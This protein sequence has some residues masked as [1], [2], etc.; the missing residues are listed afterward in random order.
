MQLGVSSSDVLLSIIDQAKSGPDLPAAA[1]LDRSLTYDELVHEVA[2]VAAGL[3]DAGVVEGDRVALLLANS[4]N[5]VVA[6]LASLWLGATFVPFAVT[7]PDIRLISIATDC[8]PTVVVTSR[9]SDGALAHTPLLDLFAYRVFDELARGAE[10]PIATLDAS[11]IAYVIYTSGTTGAPKGVL[12]NRG[13][14]ASAVTVTA[15]ALGLSRTTRTL[16]VS[17]FHFDGSFGTLF[18]TLFAGGAVVIRPRDALLF[19]RT[20]FRAIKDERITY[21]GFSPSY[22][23]LL[24]ASPQIAELSE[25]DIDVIALGGEA[26]SV[27]D[28]RSLHAYAPNIRVFN[29]YGPTE[30]TIAVTHVHLTPEL[31]E[32]GVVPIGVPH[33]DV[34]FY[35]IDDAGQLIEDPDLMGELYIGGSQLMTGYWGAPELTAAVLRSDVVPGT[36]VYRT[37]DLMSRDRTGN[38]LYAGRSDDVIKRSGVRLSLMELSE[39]VRAIEHVTAAACLTFELEGAL[40]IAA[41]IVTDKP[42]TEFE[43]QLAARERLPDSMLPDRFFVVDE[44]PLTKSGKLDER[45]LLAEAALVTLRPTM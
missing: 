42:M 28:V 33:R 40:G 20:F 14:F 7:D 34:Y 31:V 5:F 23:R 37:G 6:A 27:S 17:P 16:C 21:T 9:E 4:V 11:S 38:Y 8:A 1:D 12:I 2:R 25:S 32:A 19:P 3:R 36:T 44:L 29:R 30:S 35:L 13:A 24:L 18:P 26:S 45:A 41:F 39:A 22:L 43:L 10:A 15:D